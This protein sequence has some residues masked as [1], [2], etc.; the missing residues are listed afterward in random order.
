MG[1][2]VRKSISPHGVPKVVARWPGFDRSL[3]TSI[4][5]L[6]RCIGSCIGLPNRANR[7][8]H[9]RA[10]GRPRGFRVLDFCGENC[11]LGL[12]LGEM[13]PAKGVPIPLGTIFVWGPPQTVHLGTQP[14]RISCFLGP[15]LGPKLGPNPGPRSGPQILGPNLIWGPDLGP[16]F[17]PRF[18]AHRAQRGPI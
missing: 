18:G 2:L 6:G 16:D 17:G 3:Y 13:G 8:H 14:S 15:N 11:F 1:L 7:D 4:G 10:Q 12:G 5:H 9:G